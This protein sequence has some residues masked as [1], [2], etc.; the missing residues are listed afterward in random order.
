MVA[1]L[2]LIVDLKGWLPPYN[3]L[4]CKNWLWLVP[5]K[6]PSVEGIAINALAYAGAV[7]FDDRKQLQQLAEMGF[8]DLLQRAA[9]D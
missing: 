8:S 9:K 6:Q 3:L 1:R 4:M 2:G 7:L 5:R